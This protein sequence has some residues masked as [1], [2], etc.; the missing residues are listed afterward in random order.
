MIMLCMWLNECVVKV[1]V[2]VKFLEK[3][4][5]EWDVDLV[6]ARRALARAAMEA[7]TLR[8]LVEDV[9]CGNGVFD[10]LIVW[11]DCMVKVFKEDVDDV[12]VYCLC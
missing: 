9:W 5:V 8:G 11:F 3:M 4:F 12:D 10:V 6:N 2:F 7:E 1:N